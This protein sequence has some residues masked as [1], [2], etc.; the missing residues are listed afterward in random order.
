MSFEGR[1]IMVFCD[2]SGIGQAAAA[3]LGSL[4]AHLVLAAQ[5]QEY[6][7]EAAACLKGKRCLTVPCKLTA[8][9]EVR[10]AVRKAVEA[11]GVKLDGCAFLIGNVSVFSLRTIKEDALLNMFQMNVFSL[12]AALQ[13]FAS[14]R[15]SSDGSSFV[16]L[17]SRAAAV[18]DQ[19]QGVYGATKAA[20]STYVTAAAKELS[21]RKIRV[22]AICPEAVDTQTCA[23]WKKNLTPAQIKAVYP[24]GQLTVEDMADTVLYLLSDYSKKVTGQSIWLSAG[25]NG[26]PIGNTVFEM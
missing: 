26:G 13:A 7:E 24:L 8:F 11:D 16:A 25:N 6:L 22:N 5:D 20:V 23:I 10:D 15:V 21:A 2:A 4:G 14:Q 1:K 19:G 3:R 18:P 9:N 12:V 17:S